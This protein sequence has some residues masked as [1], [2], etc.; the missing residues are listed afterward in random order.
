M[1]GGG[2]LPPPRPPR[3]PLGCL[4]RCRGVV[5]L[6]LLTAALV[7]A[8]FLLGHGILA[9]CGWRRWNWCA[10]AVGYAAL[11]IVFGQLVDFPR[12]QRAMIALVIAVSVAALV[13][14]P[15]RRAV[16]ESALDT[17]VI[18]VGMI[19]LAA[20][21]FFAAGHPG[22]LGASVSND[23]SQHLTAAYYLR[24]LQGEL[25]VAAIGG[26][27][28]NTGYPLGPHGLAAALTRVSGL[29]EVRAFSAVTL[30]I[31]VVTAFAALGLVPTARRAARWGLAVVIGLGYLPAA[32]L[33]QG[34]FKETIQAMLVLAT[35]GLLADLTQEDERIGWRR[36]LPV[37]VLTAAAI[38]NYSYGGI[39]WTAFVVLFF[40]GAQVA[41]RRQLF[42]VIRR[43]LFAGIVAAVG[44]VVL[45][46]PEIHRIQRFR[47]SIF[48]AEDLRNKGNLAHALSPFESLGVWF[49]GDFR[50]NPEP[51]WVTWAF[52]VLALVALIGGLGWWWRRRA[53][54]LPA[55]ALAAILVWFELTQTVNIYNAA[56]GL[57][58]LAPL[59]MGAIGAPLA[60]AWSIRGARWVVP[61]RVLSVVL[62]AGA[63]V[64]S[65]G[66]LRSAP[67]G[68][69]QHADELNAMRPLVKGK[70][71]L[72]L[73]NDHFAEWELRGAKPLYTT[74]ALYAP[75]H[76][77]QHPQKRGGFPVDADNFGNRELDEVDFIV[78]AGGAYRSQIPP[79]FHLAMHT[80]SY[81]LYRRIGHTPP[82]ASI[83]PPGTP[84]AVFDCRS[85]LGKRYLK[86]YSW[87]GVQPTPVER[88]VWNGSI[89]RPGE[90][91]Q[92]HVRLRRG[93]WD[94][95]L[96]YLS[97]TDVVVR[98][99]QLQK[100]LAPNFGL[101]SSFWPAGTVTSDGHAFTLSVTSKQRNWFGRL[102]GGP[103]PMRAPLSPGL[104]PIFRVAFTRHD[105]TPRRVP[106]RA[107][108]GRY[109][110]WFAPAGSKMRGRSGHAG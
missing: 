105:V 81:D 82:R 83:E 50:F 22:I 36:G 2:G 103:T 78:V 46:G 87:A 97:R 48:G 65:F 89:A 11:L 69:G 12:H 90:T 39:I 33:A 9:L 92:M 61:A 74:N 73:D 41:R 104:N 79:N 57:V 26:D 96:Q 59:V 64:A 3:Q 47:K 20:I 102:I 19:L 54:A 71:V 99:P 108:C 14:R 55:A 1:R 86:T 49:N 68:L 43:W 40:F 75:G 21:P 72:F 56:K 7:A 62:L 28:I 109:V 29:G 10:P 70:A 77:G 34:S 91:A 45:I 51:R 16:R 66:V 23:M 93:R 4:L 32:Y 76:L 80:P 35:V 42:A 95:S 67:V 100:E 24:T 18:G 6:L 88:T 110:D 94:I 13:L 37:A 17:L 53:F 60:L 107:A 27:L 25:P 30:A 44:F 63:L 85:E 101:I 84:G 52:V 8:S 31:P 15:V 58:V 38:Y 98:A 106:I 5:G